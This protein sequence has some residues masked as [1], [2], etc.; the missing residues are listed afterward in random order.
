MKANST[1]PAMESEKWTIGF[2][3]VDVI[4]PTW[5]NDPI[6]ARAGDRELF[7]LDVNERSSG[8]VWTR[9]VL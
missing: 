4:V 9:L 6:R 8:W 1:A 5:Q 3:V 2:A 7:W